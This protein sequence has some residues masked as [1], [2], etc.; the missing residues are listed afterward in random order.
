[1]ESPAPVRRVYDSDE[2][3][4]HT[5]TQTHLNNTGRREKSKRTGG[6]IK[7]PTHIWSDQTAIM[8]HETNESGAR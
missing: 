3:E 7:I 1:M 4:L 6:G 5:H 8:R 2:K